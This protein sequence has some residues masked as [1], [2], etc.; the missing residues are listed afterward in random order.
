MYSGLPSGLSYSDSESDSEDCKTLAQNQTERQ[1]EAEKNDYQC[2][3]SVL[4]DPTEKL[5]SIDA[6]D[7]LPGV[8]PQ[9]WQVRIL[10][11]ELSMRSSF[12]FKLQ[13]K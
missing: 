13:F 10:P 9:L 8:S 2:D 5:A 7:C 3:H 6:E 11:V 4:S 1:H 12:V